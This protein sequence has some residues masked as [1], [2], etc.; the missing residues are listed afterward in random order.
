[1]N[2]RDKNII[3]DDI[4]IIAYSSFI[5][6]HHLKAKSCGTTGTILF[7]VNDAII[8]LKDYLLCPFFQFQYLRFLFEWLK[9]KEKSIKRNKM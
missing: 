9:M 7:K 3:S 8:P 2:A 4:Q 5:W 6:A 1:M